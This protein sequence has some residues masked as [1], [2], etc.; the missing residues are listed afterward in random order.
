MWRTTSPS[1][2]VLTWSSLTIMI[3]NVYDA[4]TRLSSLL[5][6]AAAGEEVIIA[7]AGRPVARLVPVDAPRPRA[8][9]QLAGLAVPEEALA[10]LTE[11]ERDAWG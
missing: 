5:D 10:P 11:A 2:P 4:K 1:L 6:R 3:I 9:G 8:G 7:R